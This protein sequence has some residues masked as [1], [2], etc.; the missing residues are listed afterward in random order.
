[1]K[2]RRLLSLLP[3][4]MRYRLYRRRL[5]LSPP[6]PGITFRLAD[7]QSELEQAFQLLHDSYVR[8]GFMKPHPSGLRVT[9]YQ[10]LP[11][12]TNLVAV[13]GSEVVGTVSLIRRSA[14]GLPIESIFDLSHIIS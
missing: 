10:A 1:M 7:N 6:S 14:F 13:V 11:A 2:I 9:K 3:K 12:T 8:S 4:T 5:Y